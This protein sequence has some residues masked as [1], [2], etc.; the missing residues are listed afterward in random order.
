MNPDHATNSQAPATTVSAGGQEH[1]E[2]VFNELQTHLAATDVEQRLA[3]RAW[4]KNHP[5]R[6]EFEVAVLEV[7]EPG[8]DV[9]RPA[10]DDVWVVVT[11]AGVCVGWWR[12]AEDVGPLIFDEQG[13]LDDVDAGAMAEMWLGRE[14][15][16]TDPISSTGLERKWAGTGVRG[17]GTVPSWLCDETAVEQVC[18]R[19][20]C[21]RAAESRSGVSL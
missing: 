5:P 15:L 16:G 17:Y 20:D 19:F 21:P 7:D 9:E 11:D 10:P 8:W 3:A 13:A 4:A 14:R 12:Q 1:A 18:A 2:A 6:S